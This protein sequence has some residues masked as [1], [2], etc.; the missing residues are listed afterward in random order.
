MEKKSRIGGFVA[1]VASAIPAAAAGTAGGAWNVA[2]G[3]GG[4]SEGF[5]NTADSVMG[6]AREFGEDYGR[7]IAGGFLHG[8]ADAAGRR[9]VDR[10]HE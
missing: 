4:F 5:D 3:H 1:E 2:T 8:A 9:A 6:A 7:A 10:R